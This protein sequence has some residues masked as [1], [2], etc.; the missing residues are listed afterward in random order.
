MRIHYSNLY[1]NESHIDKYTGTSITI[2]FGG[3]YSMNSK[4]RLGFKID[5][6][7]KKVRINKSSGKE[8]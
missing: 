6:K 4:V 2:D 8:I 3:V 1:V 5:N 7:N